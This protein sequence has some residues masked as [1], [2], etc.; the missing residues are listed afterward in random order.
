LLE[1]VPAYR[2][3]IEPSLVNNGIAMPLWLDPLD[4]GERFIRSPEADDLPALTFSD[5]LLQARGELPKSELFEAWRLVNQMGTVFQR[6][7]V[8]APGTPPEAIVAI[9]KAIDKFADDAT[10]KED[11]LKSIKLVP[12]YLSNAKTAALFSRVADPEP[13]LQT[14]LRAYIDKV[15]PGAP[16]SKPETD[17]PSR[18]SQP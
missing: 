5:F 10:F 2:A 14:F 3:S 4:D 1:P 8:M 16:G 11:A 9:R 7:L 12:N 17:E 13:S 6:V 18:K 15:A